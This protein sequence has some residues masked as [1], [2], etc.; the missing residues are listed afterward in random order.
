MPILGTF[1]AYG[2]AVATQ[3][4]GLPTIHLELVPDATPQQVLAYEEV[5]EPEH[6]YVED[7]EDEVR[8]YF[9]DIPIM[10]KVAY[11]ESR[12]THID[13]STGTVLRG[14]INSSDVG[15]MQINKYYHQE[16][17]ERL[18]LDLYKLEDNMAYARNLYEREGTRPWSASQACWQGGALAM[19]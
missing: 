3:V 8:E 5:A 11:C 13:P 12:F 14:Y 10:V 17:A 18:G 1:I 6:Y 2:A 16:T 7:T 9:S 15:V 4:V 19:K